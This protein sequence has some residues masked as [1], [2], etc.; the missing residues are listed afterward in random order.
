MAGELA[1]QAHR[2]SVAACER[3]PTL[4]ALDWHRLDLFLKLCLG[5][6]RISHRQFSS[7]RFCF[8]AESSA[9][10]STERFIETNA[11][12]AS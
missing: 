11:L 6:F 3:R 7:S 12:I 2:T 9:I 8:Q 4:R 5:I 10:G 1:S